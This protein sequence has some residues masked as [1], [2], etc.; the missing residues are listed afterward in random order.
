MA[1]LVCGPS[2]GSGP[3][4]EITT[5]EDFQINFVQFFKNKSSTLVHN[6]IIIMNVN[7]FFQ[8]NF[9]DTKNIN[10]ISKPCAPVFTVRLRLVAELKLSTYIVHI[11]TKSKITKSWKQYKRI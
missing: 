4:F 3:T 10:Y 7:I 6:T 2:Q 1:S 8:I 11:M 5:T 9:C